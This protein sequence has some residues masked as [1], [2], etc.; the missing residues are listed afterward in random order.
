MDTVLQGIDGVGCLLDDIIIT[1]NNYLEHMKNLETVLNRL[2]AYN[3]RLNE[4]KCRFMQ[5]DIDYL[6]HNISEKGIK[7]TESKIDSLQNA[8]VPKNLSELRSFLGLVNYYANFISNM[9]LHF[10]PLYN[11]FKKRVKYHWSAECQKYFDYIKSVI[12]S[13]KCLTHYDPKLEVR[14][15]TD[16]SSYGLGTVLSHIMPD[17]VERPIAFTSRTLTV[18]EQNYS[19]IEREAL[20]IIFGVSKFHM[21]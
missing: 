13:A 7:M 10:Q 1:G 15:A 11:L 20:S 21:H 19:Q 2:D 6:G 17:G 5:S 3:I 9:S 18:A 14:L 12:T 16:A 4:K 8:P